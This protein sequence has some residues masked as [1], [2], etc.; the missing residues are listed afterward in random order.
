MIEHPFAV[1]RPYENRV[2]VRLYGRGD[3]IHSDAALRDIESLPLV[4]A[5]QAHNNLTV[6]IREAIET[7]I[8]Q[9]DGIATDKTGIAL[10]TRGADCQIFAV[11]DPEH[12]S[13]G[14]LHAGWRGIVN[15]AIPAFVDALTKEFCTDPAR[16]IVGAG[17]S[18]CKHCAEFTDP[19]AELTGIDPRFFNGRLADL[20]AIADDQWTSLGVKT[21]NIERHPDCTK[22][23]VDRW[24][25]LRGGDKEFL[26]QG[27]RNAMTFS[28][29]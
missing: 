3:G 25:S 6:V 15:G 29:K 22:C 21:T 17:P 20:P 11:Y 2:R 13:G 27:Y 19:A 1:F 7:R 5:E 4:G 18:L 14:V 12:H 26:Q 10:H 24:Y 8:P 23:A 16:L 9:A 28:L